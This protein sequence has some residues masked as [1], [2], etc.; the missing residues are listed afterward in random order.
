M[1]IAI[2]GAS[3]LVGT[4]LVHFLEAEEHEVIQ[5]SRGEGRGRPE[6]RWIPESGLVD[7]A[8]LGPL[9]ALIHLAGESVAAHRWTS[10]V[11]AR[12][13]NSRVGPTMALARSLAAAPTPPRVFISASAIGI[14]GNRGDEVLTEESGRGEGFLADVCEAWEAAAGPARAAGIRVVHP[15]FGVILDARG[16]ALGTMRLPFSLGL[17][18]PV[19]GGR[20]YYSWVGIHDVVRAL[21][22]A[23]TQPQL[24]GPVNVTAPHPVTNAE[25]TRTLAR[26]LRRPAFLP[27]PG[28]ALTALFGEFAEA[29]LLASKRVIPAALQRAGFTFAHAQLEDALRFTLDRESARATG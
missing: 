17:G 24:H 3:G 13:R 16:G 23:I 9:D 8:A 7:A 10:E 27:V 20:Q 1:R 28:I 18:G 11:K 21:L 14:Y 5:L 15:R 12:I 25:F 26:V 2:T 19:G 4:A 29:E 22:L 6:H